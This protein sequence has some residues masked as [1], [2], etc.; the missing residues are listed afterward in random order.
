[1]NRRF[2]YRDWFHSKKSTAIEMRRFWLL[3]HKLKLKQNYGLRKVRLRS[4]QNV[5]KGE[6]S[7]KNSTPLEHSFDGKF[8]FSDQF[9]IHFNGGPSVLQAFQQFG[10]GIHF[11]EATIIAGAMSGRTSDE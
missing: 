9:G 4:H 11:H 5:Q 1:M 2:A 7:S 8:G 10:Y 6:K 3:K